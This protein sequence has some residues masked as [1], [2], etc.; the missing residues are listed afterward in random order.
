VSDGSGQDRALLRKGSQMLQQAGY[1]VKNGK[2]VD[3]NGEPVTIEFLLDEPSFQ[4]H[5]APFIK[6][7]GLLGIEATMR[8]VDPVQYK[9]RTDDFDFD[10]TVERFNF[11]TTPGDS[12]RSYFSSQ[13][14]KLNG[15]YNLAGIADPAIDAMVEKIIAAATR[16][17]LTVACRAL[18]RLV[19]AG[20]YWIPHWYLAAHRIAYWD[21]FGFPPKKPG[22]ARG[23]PETW[24]YDAA[25]AAKLERG[26]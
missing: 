26:N 25:K 14:A 20:R 15:S 12:L 11:S 7:L 19:R 21:L 17:D 10:I 16:H 2:R 13:S 8:L 4:P 1:V 9:K 3:A 5:H 6:N 24:W 22:F 23:F 18:D